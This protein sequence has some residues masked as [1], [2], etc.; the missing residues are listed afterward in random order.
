MSGCAS[1][2]SFTDYDQRADE[3]VSQWVQG[4]PSNL[5]MLQDARAAYE[6]AREAGLALL[7][8]NTK[9]RAALES[10][11]SW[12]R[13]VPGAMT[14]GELLLSGCPNDLQSSLDAARAALAK[15]QD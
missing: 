4:H 2:Y 14:A 1:G 15:D 7:A 8:E 10:L 13:T 11:A 3:P 9:L 5:L 12:F 6:D